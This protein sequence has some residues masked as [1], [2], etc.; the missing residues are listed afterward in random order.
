MEWFIESTHIENKNSHHGDFV[1]ALPDEEVE[2]KLRYIFDLMSTDEKR[3]AISVFKNKGLSGLMPLVL[4]ASSVVPK[5]ILGQCDT[6][7]NT[8]PASGVS[9]QNKKAG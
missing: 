8:Q 7:D 4:D 6:V 5:E 3:K 2:N 9:T 1:S